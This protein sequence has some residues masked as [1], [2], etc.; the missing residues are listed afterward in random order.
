MSDSEELVE[1]LRQGELQLYELENHTDH[2]T[3][4]NARRQLLEREETTD[5]SMIGSYS[6]AAET[7]DPNIENMIG[8][9]QIPIGVA[10]PLP[11][12]GTHASD[13]YHVPLATTEGALVA[14]VNR[15]CSL[16]RKAGGVTAR[17][18]ATGMTRAPVFAV[19]DVETGSRI[20]EWVDDH[21]DKLAAAAEETTN[22][23]RLV[24]I[25]PHLVG[26]RLFLRFRFTTGD[27]MGMN[28]VTIACRAACDRIEAETDAELISLTGN[29]CSD[30]KPAAINAITGRGRTVTAE[31]IIGEDLIEEVLG[32]TPEAMSELHRSKNVL[33]SQKAV[34]LGF[35]AHAANVIAATF[36]ATGQDEAHVVEGAN[37]IT[38]LRTVDG[39]LEASVTCASLQ[40]GTVG[41]GTALPC[42]QEALSLLGVAGGGDPPGA[43]ADQLAEIIAAGVL[44]GELSL[45]GALTARQLS[46]AHEELGR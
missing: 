1:K 46:S 3:A 42:Q 9:V 12:D 37:T 19:P 8:A 6:F 5:L 30:K 24:A 10:G 7:A 35:N 22:F 16:L 41:G 43:N 15:G 25:T 31:A 33:G 28:M 14:S 2:D 21:F 23:G 40:V 26:R 44:A 36:L 13:S 4:A 32:T 45:I 27:A 39:N 17:V 38:S 11:V 20:I 34:S 18:T 29:L